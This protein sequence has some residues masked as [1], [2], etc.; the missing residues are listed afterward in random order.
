MELFLLRT[1]DGSLCYRKRFEFS[2]QDQQYDLEF[3][4]HHLS[5][6]VGGMGGAVL[7]LIDLEQLQDPIRS[8]QRIDLKFTADWEELNVAISPNEQFLFIS[9]VGEPY[10]RLNE[11]TYQLLCVD[12][13]NG[14]YLPYQAW[15]PDDNILDTARGW[16]IS[17]DESLKDVTVDDLRVVLMDQYLD[18]DVE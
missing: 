9:G 17:H 13:W 1:S 14:A 10:R 8:L 12:L 3:T 18:E 7:F 4:R 15:L 6:V 2:D 5:V 16:I 11:P